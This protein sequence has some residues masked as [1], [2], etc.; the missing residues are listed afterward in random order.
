MRKRHLL[1]L[2]LAA[3]ML[4]QSA[5]LPVWAQEDAEQT[6]AEETLPEEETEQT[7]ST[8]PSAQP[9]T[10][11]IDV[12]SDFDGDASVTY[13]SHSL[14]AQYPVI[15]PGELDI[16]VKAAVAYEVGTDT[17]VYAD[18]ADERL[19]PASM[20]KIMTCLVA[21]EMCD[22][23]EIVTV[24]GAAIEYLDIG[25]S[26]IVTVDGA[27]IEYLDIGGSEAEL[28][29]GEQMTMQDLLYC[30]MVMSANDAAVTIA[31]H[32]AGSEEA[33]V[34]RMNQKAA[35]LGCTNT[36][37]ANAHGLHDENHYTTATPILPM[38]TGFMMRTTIPPPGIWHGS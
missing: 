9:N 29:D 14:N 37:F 13:G 4:V 17:M 8:E 15:A 18:H 16:P 12:P 35:E 31:A 27:A 30:L 20:T 36:H 1:S 19:Y 34:E 21:L 28:V 2:F 23:S 22:L 5:V 32:L 6:V 11:P 25:G 33:F 26:E 38:P 10:T 24:D 7:E 3:V